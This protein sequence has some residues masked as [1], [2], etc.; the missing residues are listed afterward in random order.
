MIQRAAIRKSRPRQCR[1]ALM[2]GKKEVIIE[3]WLFW[4]RTLGGVC[5]WLGLLVCRMG[6]CLPGVLS[7]SNITRYQSRARANASRKKIIPQTARRG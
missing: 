1:A 7:C 5:M 2:R 4:S 3:E 6:V